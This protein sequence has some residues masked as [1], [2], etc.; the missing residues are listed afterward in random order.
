MMP[1]GQIA[2]RLTHLYSN[3]VKAASS[4][5]HP[6]E[7]VIGPPGSGKST[8][9]HGLQQF[10]NAL[11]RDIRIVNLDPA[12]DMLPYECALNITELIQLQDVM[13]EFGL[14]PNGA[15]IYCLE[16]LEA[17]LDWLLDGLQAL[18]DDEDQKADYFVFDMPG[19]VELSTNHDSL[20][21]I[22]KKLEKA[23]YRVG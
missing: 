2:S 21:N 14:G 5:H 20:K 11:E 1:Y 19:Q 12:N 9:C 4:Q 15:M 7:Q 8:Y 18:Q 3:G 23:G 22:I 16:Y 10:F 17:N 13:D 6:P